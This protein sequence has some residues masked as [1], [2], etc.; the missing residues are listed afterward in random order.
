MGLIGGVDFHIEVPREKSLYSVLLAEVDGANV[1]NCDEDDPILE[2]VQG[3]VVTIRIDQRDIPDMVAWLM[4]EYC[5]WRTKEDAKVRG[6]RDPQ[7][8]TGSGGLQG[9]S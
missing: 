4:R 2:V 5:L 1:R 3:Q 8:P 6:I 9:G 7:E